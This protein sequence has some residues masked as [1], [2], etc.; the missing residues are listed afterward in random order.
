MAGPPPTTSEAEG[1]PL[2][3]VLVTKHARGG[4]AER[5]A[6]QLQQG[7]WR[8]GQR[9]WL[10]TAKGDL[11]DAT[12]LRIPRGRPRGGRAGFRLREVANRVG[13]HGG[14]PLHQAAQAGLRAASDPQGWWR[15]RR[16]R[17]RFDYPGTAAI[18]DMAPEQPDLIHCHNLHGGYFDLRQLAPMSR[19]L[20]VALTLHDQ[21]TFTGHCAHGLACERWRTGCGACP[22]LTIY[23]AIGHDG[24]RANL[25]AK[26]GIYARSRLYVTTPSR[27]LMDRARDSVLAAGTHGWAVI[28]NGVDLAVFTPGDQAAARARLGLPQDAHILLFTANWARRSPFKDWE[29]VS[30]AA[31]RAASLVADRPVLCIALGEEAPPVRFPGGELRF[32]PYHDDIEDVV[33]FYRS[34]DLY[35]HAAKAETFPTT[36][37][38]AFACGVPVVATA[39]G[40]IPEQVRSLAGAPGSWAGVAAGSSQATGILVAQGDASAM[41]AATAALLADPELRGVLAANAREDACLRFDAEA[42]VTA[43]LAWYREIIGDWRAWAAV[44]SASGS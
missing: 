43:T 1:H 18:P 17:E 10:A 9:A 34:A 7:M 23:P 16:G 30:G 22:D 13:R 12:V 24:T 4:G 35:L 36:I 26:A 11:A 41:G 31:E 37:L 8:H 14:S 33:A 21:W 19:R 25:A 15:N 42:Q 29:T 32:V 20:P 38:E 40:G 6:V 3:I 27:W 28:P 39:V 5:I 2:R 44:R